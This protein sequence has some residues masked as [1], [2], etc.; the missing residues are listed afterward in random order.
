MCP[1]SAKKISQLLLANQAPVAWCDSAAGSGTS[2][3]PKRNKTQKHNHISARE[4]EDTQTEL[5]TAQW[6][7]AL[8][9]IIVCFLMKNLW[10]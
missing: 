1:I 3:D 8:M 10:I 9:C 2:L 6:K 7:A 4:S 5:D